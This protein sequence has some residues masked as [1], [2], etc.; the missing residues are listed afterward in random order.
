M[1]TSFSELEY[2]AEKQQAHRDLFLSEIEAVTPWVEYSAL[3]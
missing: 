3:P 1:E 2:A